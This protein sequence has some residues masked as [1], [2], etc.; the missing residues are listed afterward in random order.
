M[1]KDPIDTS[2]IKAFIAKLNDVGRSQLPY[3]MQ[4]A[5]N[6]TA[7][8]AQDEALEII[9]RD[10]ENDTEWYLPS[11]R[12]GLRVVRATKKNLTATI[13]FNA[14][15]NGSHFIES[16]ITAQDRIADTRKGI[17]VPTDRFFELYPNARTNK[18]RVKLVSRLLKDKSKNRI[19][20]ARAHKN[21]YIFQ[22]LKGKVKSSR[23]G[24]TILNR[25]AL[26]LLSVMDKT[27]YRK[28]LELI[29]IVQTIFN[30]NFNKNF[31][32]AFQKA[33]ETRKSK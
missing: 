30:K 24:K 14:I 29:G 17:L 33:L 18:A 22:R 10:F 5:I 2:E 23:T 21:E 4:V 31:Y 13:G 28:R 12:F 20:E 8:E 32:T 11:R 27:K 16:H 9:K 25:S 26:P 7:R 1:N 15:K 3:A 19:F 6:N